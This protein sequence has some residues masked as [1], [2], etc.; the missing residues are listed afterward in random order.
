MPCKIWIFYERK[1]N[2]YHKM[3]DITVLTTTSNFHLLSKWCFFKINLLPMGE[4]F[5]IL[6][7]D[8]KSTALDSFVTL[9]SEIVGHLFKISLGELPWFCSLQWVVKKVTFTKK[10]WTHR[11]EEAFINSVN[12]SF[13]DR[14]TS[15]PA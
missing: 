13:K 7:L 2:W 10:L 3:G 8:Q 11:C 14:I 1:G 12:N 5:M 4:F 9:T 6:T 15:E